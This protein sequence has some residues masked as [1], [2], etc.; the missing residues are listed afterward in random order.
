MDAYTVSPRKWPLIVAMLF[1]GLVDL[2]LVLM[3]KEH[4]VRLLLGLIF[5]LM[6]VLLGAFTGARC[7]KKDVYK[8]QGQECGAQPRL[9]QPAAEP[10][11]RLYP[12]DAEYGFL[13]VLV[14]G[15]EVRLGL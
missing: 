6:I 7:C 14:L 8:R 10:D 15:R 11:G 13:G 5:L 12:P 9:S 1:C 3:E 2:F 4:T